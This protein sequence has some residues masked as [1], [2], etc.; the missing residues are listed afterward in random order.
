MI[1]DASGQPGTNVDEMKSTRDQKK[2]CKPELSFSIERILNG[3]FKKEASA[4]NN[5]AHR[6]I[7][8]P[9]EVQHHR[10]NPMQGNA[11]TNL[12]ERYE[13]LGFTRYNPPKLPS[14]FIYLIVR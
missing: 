9:P 7:V 2:I 6:T 12:L 11:A 1:V 14:K 4:R 3:S 10:K 13:W 5:R 8:H